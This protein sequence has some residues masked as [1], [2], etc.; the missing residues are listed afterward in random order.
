VSTSK[1]IAMVE[2]KELSKEDIA[3]RAY[4]L[5]VQRGGEP[6]KDV[7]DWVTAEKELSS[8][9]VAGPVGTKGLQVSRN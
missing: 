7:E 6:G 4:E 5:Y 2:R 9:V 8:E 1:E 3:H